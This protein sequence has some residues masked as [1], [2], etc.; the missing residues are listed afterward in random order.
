MGSESMEA[1]VMD[2]LQ[3]RISQDDITHEKD[4][5]ILCT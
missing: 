4:E 3:N 1:K 2:R 5:V